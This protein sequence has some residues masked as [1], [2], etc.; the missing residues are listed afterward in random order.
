M[1]F[2]EINYFLADNYVLLCRYMR[3]EYFILKVETR[4]IKMLVNIMLI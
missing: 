1:Y 2:L 3:D 4:M